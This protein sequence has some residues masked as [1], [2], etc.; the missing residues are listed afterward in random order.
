[1]RVI[2]DTNIPSDI[3]FYTPAGKPAQ[4]IKIKVIPA[5]NMTPR[6]CGLAIA[7][8]FHAPSK[9]ELIKSFF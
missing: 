1:M 6:V 7:A 2:S 9:Y 4:T 8:C 5:D 3:E